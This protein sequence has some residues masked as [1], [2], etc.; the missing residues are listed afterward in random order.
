MLRINLTILTNSISKR[1][2]DHRERPE[3]EPFGGQH[4]ANLNLALLD[5]LPPYHGLAADEARA[6]VYSTRST[7]H[8][9]VTID[10]FVNPSY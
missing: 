10:Q 9:F 5:V 6:Q 2:R 3:G 4:R 8:T 7:P 1:Q